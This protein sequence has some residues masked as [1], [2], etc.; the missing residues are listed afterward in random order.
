MDDLE[1][2]LYHD[3]SSGIDVPDKIKTI[4]EESLK[5]T[6]IKK[7]KYPFL[8]VALATCA[9]LILTVGIVY[10]GTKVYDA[11]W[12]E[13]EKVVGPEDNVNEKD[14]MNN[15]T[16]T[17][18]EGREKAKKILKDFGY[19]NEIIKSI[20][21]ET[22]AQNYDIIWKCE[23]QNNIFVE[24]DAKGEEYLAISYDERKI[25]SENIPKKQIDKKEAETLARRICEKY[26]YELNKYNKVYTIPYVD[27]N[28]FKW[29]D[30][31]KETK[32]YQWN[33]IFSKTYENGINSF[34]NIRISF[35]AG[36]E[37]VYYFMYE[38]AN[39]DD[40]PIVIEEEEAKKIVLEAEQ[41]IQSDYEIENIHVNLD[42][43]QMN[44][45]AYLRMEDYNLYS[46]QY[47]GNIREDFKDEEYTRY[48]TDNPVRKVWMVTIECDEVSKN[49]EPIDKYY[50]YQ[51]DA[52]T[53]EITGGS[54]IYYLLKL[55]DKL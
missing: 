32:A 11:I 44:G 38:N 2:K 17:E 43:A 25:L 35:I 47:Y 33:V 20:N 48:R 1:K 13:P 30:D 9:C 21:I 10:A 49:G 3:L 14:I 41:K 37:V 50:T 29:G 53:G 27:N 55:Q 40:N 54:H 42:I 22:N 8:K 31:E 12:K 6:N 52:T 34:E 51:V 16:M 5:D 23:T 45:D 4:I 15:N 39:I 36:A 26:G 46:K 18:E 19:E 28:S 7:K 24:F